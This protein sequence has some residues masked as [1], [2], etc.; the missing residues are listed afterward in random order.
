MRILVV[1]AGVIGTVYGAHLAAS[2]HAV[3]VLARRPR[4]DDVAQTGLT[5]LEVTSGARTSAPVSVVADLST[6]PFDLVLVAVRTDQV[7][8]ACQLLTRAC[9][10]PTV[11]VF[12][13]N[14]DGSATIPAGLPGPVR[15]GFPGIGGVL[16]DGVARYVRID[17]Q[18][19]T[20]QAGTD[21][22]LAGFVT[23]LRGRGFAVTR[24]PDMPR[25]LALHAT[26]VACVAAA[27]Y[28][29]G[30]DPARLAADRPTL[31]LM[32]RAITEGFAA[33]RAV[34]RGGPPRNLALLHHR[35][36]LPVAVRYWARV[37][38]SPMGEL[39]FAAHARHA[40][41]EMLALS[42][43]VRRQVAGQP[44]IDHL[45]RLLASTTAFGTR[46]MSLGD[47]VVG[48]TVVGDN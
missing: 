36:M 28:R 25:W 40:S 2:G 21:P 12:G 1:G 11:L 16:A 23:A 45:Q 47:T 20:V 24:T 34:G 30:A 9:G 4:T 14:P 41:A 42:A 43:D 32:C 33:Q 7:A 38:R 48:D 39:C 19:T 29:C 31:T 46:P 27:L 35:L 18:P 26:F 3:S 22:A 6:D 8:A 37:M 44:H 10:T 5:A 17:Q 13:N 15:L